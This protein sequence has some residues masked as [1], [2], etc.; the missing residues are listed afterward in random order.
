MLLVYICLV[1]LVIFVFLALTKKYRNP[2]RMYMV[3]GKK[4]SGKSTFLIKKAYKY[5]KKGYTIYTNMLDCMLPNA[6]IVNLEDIGE[7]TPEPKSVCMWDEVGMIYD[8]RQFKAFKPATRDWYKLQRHYHCI[9]YLASQTWD[10]DKKLRDLTDGMY[11][12][13]N[14]LGILSIAKRISRKVVLTEA[15]SDNESRISEN[16][17][18]MPIWNWSFTWIPKWKKYFDSFH[19]PELP[20][21]GYHLVPNVPISAGAIT[22]GEKKRLRKVLLKKSR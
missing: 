11:L 12:C 10:I 7:F 9:V 13:L 14:C 22:D 20:Y 16:L 15:T 8:N 3:F 4:G 19:A 17:A 1:F 2:W 6:R 18:F 21:I 5:Q